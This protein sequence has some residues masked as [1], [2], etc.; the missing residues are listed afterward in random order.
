MDAFKEFLNTHVAVS[1]S[2]WNEIAKRLTAVTYH[3]GDVLTKAGQ[4]EQRLYFIQSGIIRLY[5]EFEH[6]DVTINFAFPN[7]FVNAYTSFLTQTPSDFHLTALTSCS[8]LYITK[9]DLEKLYALTTCG[10][11]LGRIFAEKLF[12]YLSKRENDFMIKSPTQRYLDL[13]VEQPQLIQEIPQKYL[14]SYIG[15]TPQALSRIRAKT[16]Q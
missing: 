15:I 4:I 16:A 3:K 12:L 8:L 13:F 2:D 10:D 1:Q 11:V 5:Y 9:S 6:K 7:N 14:A